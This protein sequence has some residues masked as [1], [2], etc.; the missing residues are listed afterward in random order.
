MSVPSPSAQPASAAEIPALPPGATVEQVELHWYRHVYQGDRVKQLSFRAVMMGGIIGMLM[1]IAG[2]YTTLKI[3]WS[4]GVAITACV[5]SYVLWNV[6]RGLSGGRLSQMTILENN[7]MQ[8]TA[9][10]AGYS[11]GATIATAFGAML[12]LKEGDPKTWD[13]QSPWIVGAFTLTTAALG[14]F[15]AIP[16]KRQMINREQLPFP[17]G[18]AAASTLKS[19]YAEGREAVQKAYSLV[20]ALLAG[21][22]VGFLNTGEGGLKVVDEFFEFFQK[23]VFSI[24]LPEQV[25]LTLFGTGLYPDKTRPV[26]Y[27]FEP[28]VLLI[29]AGMIVGMRVSLSMLAGSLLLYFVVGPQLV[30][31]DLRNAGVEGY[32]HSIDLIAGGTIYHVTRWALWGGTSLMVFASLT[33][34]ALQWKTIL[35]SFG[36]GRAP[37]ADTPGSAADHEELERHIRRIEV[38]NSW[39]IAGMIPITIGVVLVNYLAFQISIPLGLLAV[40]MSFVLSMVACRATG[41]TDT[42]P[43]GAMGKVMQ[44]LFAV[45]PGA[46]G[47]KTINL[48][49]AGIAANSASSSA[50]LLTD[51]RSGYILGANPRQQFL[52]QFAG[53]FFG[54]L[55]IVPA[56]YLLVPSKSALEKFNPPA[57]NMWKA[58]AEVLAGKNGLAAL[59][60]SAKIAIL[61]GAV[62]GCVLPIIEKLFPKARPYM[63]SAMGLGLAWVVTFSNSFAFAIGAVIAWLWATL[64]SRSADKFTIP[65]ASGLVAGESLMKAIL[66]MS[67]TG[68]GLW[69]QFVSGK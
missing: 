67:A 16:M 9:S 14:V 53:I 37:Q 2:L 42:N 3:G 47:N 58:V 56:W 26:G 54:T 59:P 57:T 28:S 45:L 5:I 10:A 13:V 4:F 6:F 32:V 60:D 11:T 17:S 41:E 8:S 1:S 30:A 51:L 64:A 63:P 27:Y 19:L 34:L 44:L 12:L 66:A 20:A 49:S 50:D 29:A 69:Q 68:V 22:V 55:A 43:I 62:V 52:A 40:G 33:A 46:A 48:M 35:R 31:M 38:P 7:C 15:L 21:A 39:F 23:R 18:I 25:N 61:V 65:I 24:R 36:V